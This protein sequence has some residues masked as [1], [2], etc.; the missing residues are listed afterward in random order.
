MNP[1][2]LLLLVLLCF[3]NQPFCS[4]SLLKA[5]AFGIARGFNF[6]KDVLDIFSNLCPLLPEYNCSSLVTP[7]LYQTNDIDNSST[8]PDISIGMFIVNI[9][10]GGGVS[11]QY[12]PLIIDT[13]L[14]YT[15]MLCRPCG[16]SC[17]TDLP[18]YDPSL[19]STFSNYTCPNSECPN[20]DDYVSCSD[21]SCMYNY[22]DPPYVSS[23]GK[24]VNDTFDISS[25]PI[26][27]GCGEMN[28][29][30]YGSSLGYLG[31]G[32]TGL[33]FLSQ[34]QNYGKFS[35]C[36]SS[37]D[38]GAFLLG[39]D[40]QLQTA[41]QS[42][43]FLTNQLVPRLY[44]VNFT[45]TSIGAQYVENS[46]PDGNGEMILYSSTVFTYLEE[47]TYS[48]TKD[49]F[50]SQMSSYG[51]VNASEYGYDLCFAITPGEQPK[52]PQL[53]LHFDGADFRPK[54]SDSYFQ[55]VDSNG[56]VGCLLLFPFQGVSILGSLMQ[57]DTH[58]IYDVSNRIFQFESINCSTLIS[59]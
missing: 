42:T 46:Q 22:T 35:Y 50:L 5:G 38:E 57:L 26:T 17:S 44:Y 1:K 52:V 14:D 16:D 48:A 7:R 2:L 4:A 20:L 31:L 27:F 40:A 43:S 33:S 25:V 23:I 19:S 6:F 51:Q 37:S 41:G 9:T 53:T 30:N 32:A 28:T 34:D 3:P 10:V 54:T 18:V 21:G 47:S 8:M 55:P 29:G 45:G 49:E 24:L 12:V 11:P 36:I 13:A 39:S 58:M 59:A 15:F 56:T